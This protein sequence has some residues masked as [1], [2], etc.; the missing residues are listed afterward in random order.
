MVEELMHMLTSM[1]LY[2]VQYDQTAT[3]TCNAQGLTRYTVTWQKVGGSLPSRALRRDR[4]LEIRN[5]RNEDEGRYHCIA[6]GEDGRRADA[7]VD[8]NVI[9][10][11][12]TISKYDVQYDQTATL[13]CNAQGLTRYTVTWQKVGGSLPS[14]ALRRDRTLEI[15]NARN[16]DEGRYHCIAI[17]ED[18][19]RADAYVD[20]NVIGTAPT[21]SKYDVQYDQTA[22]LTCNAQG[23]TRYTVTWQKVGGSLPS[24][25]LRRDRTLE[26]R[27]AR[28]EDE[29]RY[30][31]I[32]IGEDGRRADAYVDLNVIGTAP[33]ISKYDVQYDQTATLTCNAQGLT[34]Y[35][36]TWQKVG[37][38]LPSRALRRDRTLEIRNARNE[39]EGRYHCIAIGEDGRRADAYVDLN[40][41]G[42]APTITS[43]TVPYGQT[44]VLT[45]QVR[46][47]GA[48]TVNWLKVGSRLPLTAQTI[49]NKLEIGYAR[50]EYEGRYQCVA[51]N[52]AGE[53]LK[54]FVDLTVVGS[55]PS[56]SSYEVRYDQTATLTCNVQGLTSYTVTWQKVRGSLPS[57]AF[58]R[59][60][61]LVIR[62]ARN[63]DE[64]RYHCIATGSD[65]QV[66]EGYIDLNVVGSPPTFSTYEVQYGQTASIT[67]KVPGLE[68]YSVRWLK[69]GSSLP[70]NANVRERTLIISQAR[71]EDEGRYHCI[72]TT[73]DGKRIDAY[74]DLT[75][76]GSA[77]T[78]TPYEVI[79]GQT[80]SLTCNIRGGSAGTYTFTWKRV[81]SRLPATAVQRDQ[82]LLITS[83][84]YN[85]E[86]RYHCIAT[87]LDGEKFEGYVDLIV[88]GTP[89]PKISTYEVEYGQT[90]TMICSIEN[91]RKTYTI[92]W[93]K[94]SK[95][96]GAL[97]QYAIRRDRQLIIRNAR[98]E[99]QGRYQ[100]IAIDADGK[101]F[102]SFIDFTVTGSAP[103][104]ITKYEVQYGQTAMLTC[105]V[106]QTD[107]SA[108]F[109]VVWQ[110][111]GS[112]LPNY[113]VQKDNVL[114]I[115]QTRR[116]DAGRYRCIATSPDGGQIDAF[117]DLTVIG[118]A[119]VT[120]YDV[121]YGQ[122]ATLTCSVLLNGDYTINW[123]RL[124]GRLPANAII[125]DRILEIPQ[126][127]TA[128]AGRYQCIARDKNGRQIDVFVDLRVTGTPPPIPSFEV[129]Y[130]E[131]AQ[132]VCNV[133]TNGQYS[134]VWQKVDGTL[135]DYVIMR[136]RVLEIRQSKTEDTGR[137]RCIATGPD[138]QIRRLD[139]DLIVTGSAPV[140]TSRRVPYGQTATLNCN[141]DGSERYT[142]T[143]ER[144]DA[145]LPVN[146]IRRG[147][148]LEIHS[149]RTEDEGRYHCIALS[150][151]GQRL[152]A[153][154]DLTVYG[155]EPVITAREVKLG[156]TA[157]LNCN[158][159]GS[160]FTITWQR[161]GAR[162][163]VNSATRG[164]S[165]LEIQNAKYEDQGRYHCIASSADGT[166]LDAF[167]DLTVVGS[168]PAVIAKKEVPFGE[169]ARLNCNV[170]GGDYQITWERVNGGLPENSAVLRTVLEIRDV[171][172]ED[173]G[174]YHCTAVSP[175]GEKLDAYLDLTVT[176]GPVPVRTVNEGDNARL[177]CNV[178]D[179]YTV[180][181]RRVDAALSLNAVVENKRIE[182][183]NVQV[184]DT[185]R[186]ECLSRSATETHKAYVD[187]LVKPR[188][189][190]PRTVVTVGDTAQ[191]TCNTNGAVSDRIEWSRVNGRLP[192]NAII[193]NSVVEIPQVKLVDTG[194][195]TCISIATDGSRKQA[196][197]DLI[198]N[199]QSQTPQVNVKLGDTARLTC[200]PQKRGPHTYQWFKLGEI[201]AINRN[202][203]QR[204]LLI[205]RVVETDAGSYTCRATGPDGT[206]ELPM[207]IN[208]L[209]SGGGNE[210]ENGYPSHKVGV[211]ETA[212]LKCDV[213]GEGFQIS[214]SRSGGTLSPY[215]IVQDRVLEI[216]D[217]RPEDQGRY[218]CTAVGPRGSTQAKIDLFVIDS[219]PNAPRIVALPGQRTTLTC[220]L[221]GVAPHF[222]TW[223]KLDGAMSS[224]AVERNEIL[225]I[226]NVG[227][228]DYGR[229]MCTVRSS[230]GRSV[231]R[232]I[233]LIRP[234]T[235]PGVTIS[236][237]QYEVHLGKTAR[238][239][240]EVR[241][242]T[243][244]TV[245][246][247]KRPGGK[248]L[249]PFAI[250]RNGLLEIRQVTSDDAGQY[251][252]QVTDTTD[253]GAP[254]RQAFTELIIVVLPE[255]QVGP[256]KSVTRYIGNDVELRCDTTGSPAPRVFWEKDG[257]TLPPQITVQDGRLKIF[258][259]QLVD[260][261]RYYCTAS[262]SGGSDR[263]FVQ[264]NVYDRS[265][266]P[267]E[268]Y[269]NITQISSRTETVALGDKV[270]FTCEV[271][272]TPRP[273]IQWLRDGAQ[274]PPSAIIEDYKLIIPSVAKED[275]GRYRCMARNVAGAVQAV[276][277]LVVK[278]PD[279]PL[280]TESIIQTA[281]VGSRVDIKC[282]NPTDENGVIWTKKDGPL[283]RKHEIQ[284]G[285]LTI[286]GITE[287]NAGVYVCKIQGLTQ[288]SVEQ[289]V[290]LVV[291]ALVPYFKQQ[292]SNSY[293]S[294]PTLPDAKLNFDV[295][296]SFYPE[297]ADGLI[298]YNGQFENGNG[299]FV[300]FG[301]QNGY[302][303]FRF[304]CGSGPAIIKSEGPVSLQKWHKAEL[305]RNKRNGT[306]I[307]DGK[308]T[309]GQSE[310]RFQGLDLQ[311]NCY[312]G[313]V[314][315]FNK[316]SRK[317][318]LTQGFIGAVSRVDIRGV[319]LD[320]SSDSEKLAGITDFPVC[321]NRPC[322]NGGTCIPANTDIGYRCSC[323]QGFTGLTCELKGEGCFRGACGVRG[324][325]Y[326]LPN[327][328]IRCACP[329][330]KS[331]NRCQ[332]GVI[333]EDPAFDQTSYIAYDPLQDASQGV[334]I[335]LLFKANTLD[336][337][338][339]LYNG[340][341]RDGGGDFLSLTI[342]DRRIE[343]RYDSGSGT[344][345]ITS[346]NR[347]QIGKWTRVV[348]ERSQRDGMLTVDAG[349]TVKV[350]NPSFEAGISP[351]NMVGLNLRRHLFIGGVNPD[352][353]IAPGVGV[354]TG[355]RGCIGQLEVNNYGIDL[356]N[357][358]VDSSDIKD[359]G[360]KLPCLRQPCQ[361]GGICRGASDGGYTCQCPTTHTGK[362]CEI[363]INYCVT[364]RPCQNGGKC[365]AV[366]DSFICMCPLGFSGRTCNSRVTL[367]SSVRL[368]GKG[369]YELPASL[370][371]HTNS[372]EHE[373]ITITFST[374]EPN[375]LLFWHGQNPN[376]PGQDDDYL[377]IALRDGR[378]EL[379]YELGTGI[380]NIVTNERYNDGLTHTIVTE[381]TGR[382]GELKV[383]N[384]RK[385]SGSSGGLLQKLNTKGNIYI[386]GVPDFKFMTAGRYK[387]GLNGCIS[388][389]IQNRGNVNVGATALSG[390][391]LEPCL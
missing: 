322:R 276:I 279:Y 351:G 380:A 373:V 148:S 135:P 11:A 128:D 50:K 68:L 216:R 367:Y 303:E 87:R 224:D 307:L 346:Q 167:V 295:T 286:E 227:S 164:D 355:L 342:R 366:G 208:V 73:P 275:E 250:A 186:Y 109:A 192:N 19:R 249:P 300:S 175:T 165:G 390:F 339:L 48:F 246:S 234:D 116:D 47:S 272:G 359:C 239:L 133:Q 369:Y 265:T 6:I 4:T 205:S 189:T 56:V 316:I 107:P 202:P 140:L 183:P 65:G 169:T 252:C 126:A 112:N 69:V 317:A 299:D 137:Y 5:A 290:E 331:G 199:D 197:V 321:R 325:C 327:Q 98:T 222:V 20:L 105:K 71:T 388:V 314:P 210:P 75:V 72:A 229:Y 372:Q 296:I 110:K 180:S 236:Q 268:N 274:M 55:E 245:V 101:Q 7:Y 62:N 256:S 60:R 308:K 238:L 302:G 284:N 379:S 320:M 374:N 281:S 215:A 97:P 32:A 214:W 221:T 258:N 292:A 33:T 129:R 2:D 318:G 225:D 188:E 29:G 173:E 38:S 273:K 365:E 123:V 168:S 46:G 288:G 212:K 241:D 338:I 111:V 136:D 381:R 18:G 170:E 309:V 174:R 43:L 306:L 139:L 41:I 293:V 289:L 1:L 298:L 146:S 88:T 154:V 269:S 157:T 218:V 23:L 131:P 156:S 353:V 122:T 17:G 305:K 263:D 144:I 312:V 36:V 203:D 223:R 51:V 191:I 319:P 328:G 243:A 375:A 172:I 358:A 233:E 262:N 310:G 253:S 96:G 76:K 196:Q 324:K 93:Q 343:L 313:G 130:G 16:E 77:P 181:W 28:N 134:I 82:T 231:D 187:L 78:I 376:T 340:Q 198:V 230:D 67:C 347:V 200:N 391:N 160:D 255:V 329:I 383:D 92:R 287:D 211:G 264:L 90:A 124:D 125:R 378:V 206:E 34:R 113:A 182:I 326:D 194:R 301:L 127:R 360:D 30:H 361:N 166:R 204:V 12:P 294:F 39:D 260:S 297:S 163:P 350:A 118:S 84:R 179:E 354:V 280:A 341:R 184:E 79:Y 345:V 330:G 247:W 99:D 220:R 80:A 153:Y 14:R 159:Q 94:V 142:I 120:I 25:A 145:Q 81:G 22:T 162:L 54:G 334:M 143:W 344:A 40:V 270:D 254:S 235:R 57:R 332:Q 261:G 115:S 132:L 66:N 207:I 13:T 357:S 195:Y 352:E 244:S 119:P 44:A 141:V 155:S 103:P 237:P 147:N 83:A 95:A 387:S 178:G 384:G 385:Y 74:V 177:T 282:P 10:T 349:M 240:C 185:G 37:G 61:T 151:D 335:K 42:S 201:R 114:E 193:Q 161:V 242:K 213:Q 377:S 31:C 251:V 389:D 171:K 285:I 257:G 64:G 152:D 364:N 267:D 370:L 91:E 382:N 45:C 150:P 368:R 336:D 100:C 70:Q 158:V 363:E 21:I 311:L 53:V 176:G 259:L 362:R 266:G 106:T 89:A 333:I 219:Q 386:G 248:R 108:R 304:D 323:L 102:E 59:D 8:L 315:E 277:D 226:S 15:R 348:A 35:T 9:G 63:E 27:N 86:G 209:G 337:A 232:Y 121:R 138:G 283:P 271:Q 190:I 3:L 217:V 24:R 85:D 117:V 149:A 26:I 356:V 49:D 52:E 371:P 104:S 278:T 58:R 228:R 291:G